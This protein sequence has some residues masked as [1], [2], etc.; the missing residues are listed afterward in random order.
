[1]G[2]LS[3]DDGRCEMTTQNA[4]TVTYTVTGMTCGHCENAVREEVGAIPGVVGVDVR[5]S[6]G[7]LKISV[8]D[9][10]T[11]ADQAVLDAVDEAGYSAVRR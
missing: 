6:T 5:A 8:E 2:V 9:G 10:T 11:I 7:Q 3:E 1:M 4:S